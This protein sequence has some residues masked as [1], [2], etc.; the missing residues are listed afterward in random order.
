MAVPLTHLLFCVC[1]PFYFNIIGSSVPFHWGIFVF[2]FVCLFVC[3]LVSYLNWDEPWHCMLLC[4]KCHIILL[5]KFEIRNTQTVQSKPLSLVCVA[6]ALR[7]ILADILIAAAAKIKIEISGPCGRFNG[8]QYDISSAKPINCA[9]L[10]RTETIN[11]FHL[12]PE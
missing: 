5:F 9:V 12:E 6:F 2:P 1:D 4:I 7:L 10:F 11:T 8:T 3:C